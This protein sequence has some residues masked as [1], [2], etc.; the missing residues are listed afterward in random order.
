MKHI[1]F[2]LIGLIAAF[3]SAGAEEKHL[4]EL[5]VGEFQTLEVYDN[6]N[7]E[8]RC[9]PDSAGYVVFY[10]EEKYADAFIITPN[11]KGNL[12]IQVATD[13]ANLSTLPTLTVYSN[14]LTKVSNKGDHTVTVCSPTPC[15]DF[16]ATIEGNG[17]L[18]I[19]NL[20]ATTFEANIKT[21]NGSIVAN[22]KCD[23]AECK[24]IG[25]GS[26]D[27]L[28]L[29]T[30]VVKCKAMGTGSISCEPLE[31]LKVKCIGSTK[32]YYKGKPKLID[33]K[34]GGTLIQIKETRKN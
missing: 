21:G 1:L 27:I 7:V 14:Y 9:L 34:G 20:K 25:T 11:N 23:I 18:V 26:I 4:Y 5:R 33:K 12:K 17:R 24:L 8:W 22:G 3:T 29:A 10:A 15:P 30:D 28:G 6:V 32:I 19:E 13:N 2:A 16:N 31:E